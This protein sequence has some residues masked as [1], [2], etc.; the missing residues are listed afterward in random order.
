VISGARSKKIA[1]DLVISETTVKLHRSNMMRKMHAKSITNLFSAWD[2]ATILA[3]VASGEEEIQQCLKRLDVLA[4][5]RLQFGLSEVDRLQ[6]YGNLRH[7]PL[8]P[9]C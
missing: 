4:L 9:F 7:D 1:L 6:A 3:D 2:R 5:D 8:L